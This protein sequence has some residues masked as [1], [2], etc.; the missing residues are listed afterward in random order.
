MSR[1]PAPESE[2]SG[3]TKMLESTG[4]TRGSS[5]TPVESG[6]PLVSPQPQ[7][8][9]QAKIENMSSDLRNT[10][11]SQGNA[12]RNNKMSSRRSSM[13]QSTTNQGAH[14]RNQSTSTHSVASP[15]NQGVKISNHAQGTSACQTAP[16]QDQ[17]YNANTGSVPNS[18]AA[19]QNASTHNTSRVSPF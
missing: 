1:R 16:N 2:P 14:P 3:L 5:A 4:R 12:N 13:L 19:K 6:P 8:D 7:R 18:F 11:L 15:D 17:R 10:S 9:L